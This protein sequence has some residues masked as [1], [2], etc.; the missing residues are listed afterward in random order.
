MRLSREDIARQSCVMVRRWRIFGDF[1]RPLFS[2]SRVQHVS[3]LHSKFAL[4]IEFSTS[5]LFW[6]TEF[7]MAMHL[8]VT[9][10]R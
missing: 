3:D 10:V 9:L 5:W 7:S 6:R 1:L 8:H 2:G 4:M